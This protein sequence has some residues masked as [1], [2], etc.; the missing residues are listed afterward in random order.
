MIID[1]VTNSTFHDRLHEQFSYEAR[2]YLYEYLEDLSVDL[3]QDIE[4]DPVGIRCQYQEIEKEDIIKYFNDQYSYI[5]EKTFKSVDEVVEWLQ[6]RTSLVAVLEN[7]NLLF[8][9]NF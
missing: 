4:F 9:Y 3:G 8:D 1:T 7:G 5:D 6:D 2:D